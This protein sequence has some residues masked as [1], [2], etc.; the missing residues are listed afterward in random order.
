MLPGRP[1]PDEVRVGDEHA[2]RPRVRPQ[3]ADR[4]ARLDEQRLVVLEPTE[5]AHDR[6]ERVP[7]ARGSPGPAV[8]DEVVRVLGDLGIEVVHEHAQRG[9]LLPAAAGQLGAARGADGA[10]SGH[11]ARA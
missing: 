1:L 9:F 8:D 11:A 3:D 4:L 7:R 2:R 5:L 6:V 10:G